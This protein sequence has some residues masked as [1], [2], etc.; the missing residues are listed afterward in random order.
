M[1][2]AV[3]GSWCCLSNE[4]IWIRDNGLTIRDRVDSETRIDDGEDVSLF[5]L[6][7]II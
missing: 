5:S 2:S 3:V 7:K 6:G 1:Q 4:E